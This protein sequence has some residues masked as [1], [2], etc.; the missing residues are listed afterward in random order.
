[1]LLQEKMKYHAFSPSEKIVVEFILDKQELIDDYSTT[2]IAEETYTTPSILVR[3][4][5]KLD[6]NG[7][8]D[9]KKAFLK[10]V[11]YL[12]TNFHDLDANKPFHKKDNIMTITNKITQLKEES[13]NDTLS[14]IQHDSLQKAIRIL[15]ESKSVRVFT[16]SNLT[17]QAEE[18]VFK[19]RHI[20]KIADTFST[21]N[22]MYQE[23]LMTSSEDC[24]ICISYSGES[25]E[26]LTT[27]KYLKRN[28]VPMIA[29]TSIGV[30]SLYKYA[31]T[32][33]PITTREKSYTKIAG[34]S[35]L[36]GIS[37]IL[38]I[39]Y[40]CYFNVE[41]EKNY[42]RKISIS[43]QTEYREIDNSIIQDSETKF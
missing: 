20:G 1:M 36:E 41:Y 39:L 3:I 24:A 4:A 43:K 2:Q 22:T 23:A 33:L 10:E 32:V 5:K 31:D 9:L 34:F 15:S 8:R 16:I 7:Y 18:F 42:A 19:M 25:P 11:R 14:L 13:L 29:I 26:L 28:Q 30:N 12:K 27:T 17:F 38:D 35:S 40:S 37:L 21:S 6:F